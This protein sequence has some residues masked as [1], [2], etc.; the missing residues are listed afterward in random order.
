MG[1]ANMEQT[2]HGIHLRQFARS[3]IFEQSNSSLVYVSIDAGMMGAGLRKEV[4]I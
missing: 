4:F 1:Y 3:F 2:G